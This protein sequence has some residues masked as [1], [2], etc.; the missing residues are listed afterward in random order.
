MGAIFAEPLA[1]VAKV[2][3]EQDQPKGKQSATANSL[4]RK[5]MENSNEK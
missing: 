1:P 5:N 3:G 2:P 4:D